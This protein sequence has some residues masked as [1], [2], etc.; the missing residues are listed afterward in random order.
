M[1]KAWRGEPEEILA[2]IIMKLNSIGIILTS[3]IAND[4]TFMVKISRTT[5]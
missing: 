5:M 1:L 2:M 3:D 4:V